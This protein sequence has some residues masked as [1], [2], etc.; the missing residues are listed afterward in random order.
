V[1]PLSLEQSSQVTTLEVTPFK[2]NLMLLVDKSGSMDLPIDTT[3]LACFTAPGG[4]VCGQ[5]KAYL[6]DA[7]TCP[8]R[9]SV[10]STTLTEFLQVDDTAARYGLAF[11]PQPP[12]AQVSNQCIPT[13]AIQAPIPITA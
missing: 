5:D 11:F 13:L 2:P 12:D 1:T 6:C 9:W 3:D 4:E 8:T 10:L 7:G